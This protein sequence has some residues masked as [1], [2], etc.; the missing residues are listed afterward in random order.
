MEMSDGSFVAYF[1]VIDWLNTVAKRRLAWLFLVIS[2]IN[3]NY[4]ARQYI[5]IGAHAHC[6]MYNWMWPSFENGPF[7]YCE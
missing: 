2:E 3:Y 7:E 4:Y 1:L 5:D 6:C